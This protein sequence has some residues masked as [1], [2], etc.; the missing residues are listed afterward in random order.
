MVP[1]KDRK[2]KSYSHMTTAGSRSGR[3]APT[4]IAMAITSIPGTA[5]NAYMIMYE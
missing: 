2:A 5:A 4:V 1:L 3:S